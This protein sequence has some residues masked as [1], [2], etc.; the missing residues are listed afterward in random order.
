VPV[1]FHRYIAPLAALV[2][3]SWAAVLIAAPWLA[4]SGRPGAGVSALAYLVGSVVCH[5]Q[6]ARSF[7]LAGAQLPVCARC[8]GLYLSGAA[9]LLVG[10]GIAACGGRD[11]VSV[12]ASRSSWRT[13]L[14]AAALPMLAAVAL[15]WLGAWHASNAWRAASAVPPAWAL[16]AFMAES[17]S[18]QGKL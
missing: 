1:R 8:T 18:F 12:F 11:P 6:A 16:G 13:V 15:E 7:H 10:L 2:A 14:V 17:L 9:A 4:A 5:Q 3:A